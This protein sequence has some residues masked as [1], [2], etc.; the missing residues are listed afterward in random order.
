[1]I[2]IIR[3]LTQ[4][5][6]LFIGIDASHVDGFHIVVPVNLGD[7][8]RGTSPT[9]QSIR[10]RIE[11]LGILRSSFC[12][13]SIIEVSLPRFSGPFFASTAF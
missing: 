8:S 2:Y 4:R 12:H 7:D 6:W 10:V 5:S 1:M 3:S 9:R 11:T 13:R